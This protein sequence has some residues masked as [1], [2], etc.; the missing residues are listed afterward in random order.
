M[1][2]QSQHPKIAEWRR[3]GIRQSQQ[4]QLVRLMQAPLIPPY[5]N[6]V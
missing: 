3:T 4:K 1:A 6:A 5:P 2:A